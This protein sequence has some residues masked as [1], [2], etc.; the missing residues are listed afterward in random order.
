MQPPE[1]GTHKGIRDLQLGDI[2]TLGVGH[3]LTVRGV[4]QNLAVIVG[5]MAG[6][7][8][9]G[10]IGP[11]AA[12]LSIP[13]DN[14]SPISVYTPLE[15]IPPHAR[16][17]V[18]LCSG[19]ISY[20]APHLPGFSGA[21]GELGYK[22]AKVHGS[23]DPMVLIW[24][25]EERVVFLRSASFEPSTLRITRLPRNESLTEIDQVRYATRVLEEPAQHTTTVPERSL[26]KETAGH[27][28]TRHFW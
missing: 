14:H 28:F 12:L 8:L 18:P 1:L 23:L 22:V 7:V 16:S 21:Q 3:A 17:A 13:P 24:R 4:E 26:P 10:E 2:V 25:R 19:V 15:E 11:Q 27:R 20:W 5:N 6:F 9:L